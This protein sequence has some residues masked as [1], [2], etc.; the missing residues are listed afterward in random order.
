M[1]NTVAKFQFGLAAAA[2][3]MAIS[4]VVLDGDP[5]GFILIFGVCVAVALAGLALAG[6]GFN[7]RAPRF[8]SAEDA[9]PVQM[10]SLSRT[11]APRPSPWPLAG[12]V[13]LGIIGIGLAAGHTLVTVGLVA[14]VLAAAGWLSQA[15]REDPS[16]SPREGARISSRLLTPVGLPL[17][18]V[19]LI[20]VI[21]LSVSR[22][23]L[24][25]PK[26]GSIAVAFLMSVVLLVAF[27]ALASRPN[28]GRNAL[29]FLGGF[30]VVAVVSAGSVSAANGYRTFEH[31][32]SAG[33]PPVDVVARSTAFQEKTITVT[34]GQLSTIVFKNQDPIYHN[35][36]VYSES[37]TPFWNGEPIKGVK[38]I[39]YTHTFDMPPGTYTFKCD[40]HPGSMIGSFVVK[41]ASTGP[42][43]P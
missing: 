36:A 42:G 20:A 30:A 27:F 2:L 12:A 8:A 23:L 19:A 13:S 21:V 34:A 25:L 6:S 31:H 32:E 10:V 37:G 9:P 28:L 7:D 41:A 22:I 43:T 29:V 16:F 3:V 33:P 1:I 26:N 38:K 11:R 17:M 14:A 4:A 18:A 15:W 35:V 40:F 39:T 5:G 24:T